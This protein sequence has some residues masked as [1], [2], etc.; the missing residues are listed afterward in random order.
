MLDTGRERCQA[1]S[2]EFQSPEDD[3]TL[4]PDSR[5][6]RHFREEQNFSANEVR[7]SPLMREAPPGD[8]RERPQ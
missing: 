1:F 8:H 5:Y 4:G 6:D 2:L 3:R 7:R